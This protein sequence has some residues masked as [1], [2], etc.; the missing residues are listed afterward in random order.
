MIRPRLKEAEWREAK[1]AGLPVI[2]VRRK[3]AIFGGMLAWLENIRTGSLPFFNAGGESKAPVN[4]VASNT[5]QVVSPSTAL[6]LSTAW[7]CVWLNARVMA[8][9][10]LELIR[11]QG[12]KGTPAEMDPLYTVLRW[13]PNVD[14]DAFNF[15]CAMWAAEQ[16][17]GIGP[18]QKI[19]N[20]GKVVALDF[21]L[22]QF[23]TAYLT[24]AGQ[25]RYR[26][27]HPRKP[28]DLPAS[29]VFRVQSRTLDGYTGASVIEYGR[30]S[31]GL[32]QSGELAASQTFKKGLNATGFIKTEKFLKEDQ[33]DQ[34]RDSIDEFTGE[35]ENAGGIMVLE[36]GTDFTQLSMKPLDA[37]LLSSRQ[38]SVED[39]C[40]WF[41]VP[42]ILVGHASN[43]QTMW[44]SGVEQI[45]GGWLRLGLRPFITAATQAIRSQL[46]APADR[47]TLM[48][49]YDLEDLLAPD[50]A[51]RAQLYSTLSQNG[52]KTRNELREREG[53]GPMPGGDVLTV[54]SNLVPLEQLAKIAADPT[55]GGAGG[56]AQKLR[57]ALLELLALE[58]PPAA[59]REDK[60]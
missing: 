29:D 28:R 12:A 52:I 58:Q 47:M 25:L 34:F 42:P 40:R 7:S 16:L 45:F 55:A 56:P 11:Y 22:P 46:V 24:D 33:R 8:S 15:W 9:L 4:R 35:G 32:A 49:E 13:Q 54:Q 21:M 10:P 27:D 39:I 6:S 26:Y 57:D 18:A 37:E 36:G 53:D 51:A 48:A 30:H 31:F 19:M 14:V 1:H 44:G 3:G 20:G 60:P 50:S 38:F 41:N 23:L 59:K 17:W 5:G 43:G 2:P